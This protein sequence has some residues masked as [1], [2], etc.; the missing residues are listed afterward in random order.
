LKVDSQKNT[1]YILGKSRIKYSYN[2]A[3]IKSRKM[4]VNNRIG[5]LLFGVFILL[6]LVFSGSSG[7]ASFAKIKKV[8]KQIAQK[9]LSQQQYALHLDRGENVAEEVEEDEE[10]IEVDEIIEYQSYSAVV[11]KEEKNEFL[12]KRCSKQLKTTFTVCKLV[13]NYLDSLAM[14]PE[15]C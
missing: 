15:M 9:E 7:V 2:F 13:N 5:L 10:S 14:P 1:K 8:K 11:G 3:H 12:S 4:N 6:V